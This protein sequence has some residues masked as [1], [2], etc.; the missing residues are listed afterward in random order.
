MSQLIFME[1]LW[2]PIRFPLVLIYAEPH[3]LASKQQM[4]SKK[5]YAS[6]YSPFQMW[7]TYKSSTPP[8]LKL[9]ETI[10]RSTQYSSHRTAVLSAKKKKKKIKER[11]VFSLGGCKFCPYPEQ[12]LLVCVTI[13]RSIY[14]DSDI[15]WCTQAYSHRQRLI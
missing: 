8:S 2:W 12:K 7:K 9:Y 3:I 6:K 15:F 4:V 13:Y 5:G 11:S 1:F 14:S 10:S